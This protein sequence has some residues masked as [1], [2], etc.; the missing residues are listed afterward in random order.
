VKVEM[1]QLNNVKDK[2]EEKLRGR[3][4]YKASFENDLR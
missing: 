3:G 1:R 2:P 4:G